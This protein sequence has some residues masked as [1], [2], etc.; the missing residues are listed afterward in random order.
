MLLS[1]NDRFDKLKTT[2][3]GANALR[4]QLL[5]KKLAKDNDSMAAVQ[6]ER[7]IVSDGFEKMTTVTTSTERG[8]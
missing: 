8:K 3:T 2:E 7:Y 4:V 5:L 1:H 6:S